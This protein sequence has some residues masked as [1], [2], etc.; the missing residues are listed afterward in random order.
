MRKLSL[1]TGRLCAK[2]SSHFNVHVKS[3]LSQDPAAAL[4]PAGLRDQLHSH[5]RIFAQN[6]ANTLPFRA[7]S[8]QPQLANDPTR[9]ASLDA[10]SGNDPDNGTPA[11]RSA[12]QCH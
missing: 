2:K 8:F 6:P 10:D 7:P 5:V 9:P 4:Y 11:L 3:V 1:F 12:R